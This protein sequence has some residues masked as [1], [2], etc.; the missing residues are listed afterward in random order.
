MYL[1]LIKKDKNEEETRINYKI[2]PEPIQQE[3]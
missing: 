1:R 2:K 3:S